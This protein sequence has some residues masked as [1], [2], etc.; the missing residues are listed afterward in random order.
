MA[1][2][3]PICTGMR[4]LT[5]DRILLGAKPRELP[6][7]QP[8]AFELVINL[9]AAKTLGLDVPGLRDRLAATGEIA[10][11]VLV[12]KHLRAGRGRR[13]RSWRRR[14]A[15]PSSWTRRCRRCG[16]GE[17]DGMPLDEA[18]ARYGI[19]DFARDPHRAVS[20]GGE[21]RRGFMDRVR[22]RHGTRLTAVHTGRTLVVVTHGGVI[23]RCAL[24]PLPGAWTP[25]A[26][27]RAQFATRHASITHWQRRPRFDG[28]E[29]FRLVVFNDAAHLRDSR[30]G[31]CASL[32]RAARAPAERGPGAPR[33]AFSS[34]KGATA[35]HPRKSTRPNTARARRGE[36]P[37][38]L[39]VAHQHGQRAG[40]IP[41][42]N[43]RTS[44]CTRSPA[45]L[46]LRVGELDGLRTQRRPGAA[47][48][49]RCGAARPR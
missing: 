42:V 15:C 35:P 16:P 30:F 44:T 19:P 23:R 24:R 6:V 10:A 3:Y 14:S 43:A 17:A 20:P 36:R 46:G 4:R 37:P 28:T 48:S 8:T 9:K 45:K 12:A 21:S 1:P 31:P 18:V 49:R 27:L 38:G 11:D 33:R 7:E 32:G 26:L 13:R 5:A 25:T 34:P 2:I 29:G 22:R 47:E 39:L 40:L 41:R